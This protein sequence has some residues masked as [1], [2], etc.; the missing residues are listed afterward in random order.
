MT[1]ALKKDDNSAANDGKQAMPIT[2]QQAAAPATV[3]IK[4]PVKKPAIVQP[5][6]NPQRAVSRPVKL[7]PWLQLAKK[8]LIHRQVGRWFGWMVLLPWMLCALYFGGVA[9]DRYVSEASFMIEKND[10][11]SAAVGG[12]SILGITPQAGNDQ[13]ILETF[14]QSPDMLNYLQDHLD[15]RSHYTT[16]P[17]ILSRLSSDASYEDFLAYYRDHISIAFDLESGMLNLEVQG[18]T[19]QYT[20]Q[21]TQNILQ[22]SEAFV[23]EI[24]HHLA[25]EQQAFVQK[26]V[27]NAEARLRAATAALLAFQSKYGL[28]SAS[29]QGAALSGIVNELQSELARNQ[30]ELQTLTAYLNNSSPKVVTLKH[31]IAAIE[32][33]LTKERMRLANNDGIALNDLM[34]Q[35]SAL[36]LDLQLATEAYSA[37]LLAL[38]KARTEASRKIKQLVVVS[39]PQLAQDATYPKAG[40]NLTNILLLLLMA[41]ALVRMARA[42]IREHRD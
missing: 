27:I 15:L 14:I 1:E 28:L 7:Q 39:S 11:A 37:T 19:P 35:Q 12:F 17:D 5:I 13:R 30:T 34:A 32:T 3:P 25:N 24:S 10:G 2:K 16:K 18:F 33:Q 21:L 40:Y 4:K 20:Q 38:E 6:T 22:H 42:T 23:N 8:Q 36:Q 9:S 29:E 31:K 26:E 41:F